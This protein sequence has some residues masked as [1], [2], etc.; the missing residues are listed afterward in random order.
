MLKKVSLKG[1]P[2][3]RK[4]NS[5]TKEPRSSS[6]DMLPGNYH[7]YL[8]GYAYRRM[9]DKNA[10]EIVRDHTEDRRIQKVDDTTDLIQRM[11]AKVGRAKSDVRNL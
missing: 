9:D 4:Q 3:I 2:D 11:I 10:M 8:K 1:M 6:L 7:K 5:I